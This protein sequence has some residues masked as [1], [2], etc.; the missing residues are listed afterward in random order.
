MGE[1]DSFCINEIEKNLRS[2]S[3]DFDGKTELHYNIFRYYDNYLLLK[4]A[5]GLLERKYLCL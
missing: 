1:I 2:Q 3:N 5:I 4:D